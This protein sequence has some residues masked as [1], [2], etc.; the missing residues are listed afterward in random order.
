MD[1]NLLEKAMAEERWYYLHE[2]RQV[3]PCSGSELHALLAKGIISIDTSVWSRNTVGWR[4]L[5]ELSDQPVVHS[6][7]SR[8]KWAVLA[9]AIAMLGI[10]VIASE[11]ISKLG[12]GQ[13]SS[14]GSSGPLTN[15]SLMLDAAGTTTPSQV[16][17]STRAALSGETLRE[18]EFWRSIVGSND[19]DLYE[20]YL[21]RYPAGAF[22]DIAAAKIKELGV[23]T[24]A[25]PVDQDDSAASPVSNNSSKSV[26]RKRAVKAVQNTS[27]R[28]TKGR[29]WHGNIQ[30]C[31]E[32]CR[33]GELRACQILST[34][35]R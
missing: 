24:N 16:A 19:V 31:R 27:A 32:R 15:A 23:D 5:R 28:A 3:G 30:E 4:T 21:S 11:L 9:L 18:L 7:E 14:T 1:S 12:D 8:L 25:A 22:A 26:D 13:E 17:S 20:V 6:P 2:S 33:S 10:A 29:C 35:S 34:R